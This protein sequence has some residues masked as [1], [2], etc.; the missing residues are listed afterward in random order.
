MGML[1][2]LLASAGQAADSSRN[3]FLPAGEHKVSI[4]TIGYK[5]GF[6]GLSFIVE[7]DVLEST[8]AAP[9]VYSVV[10]RKQSAADPGFD[11]DAKKW[12][13]AVATEIARNSGDP[14]FTPS[15][16]DLKPENFLK[17]CSEFKL[18]GYTNKE[19]KV[20][21]MSDV[22]GTVLLVSSVPGKSQKGVA[23]T[24]HNPRPS[25]GKAE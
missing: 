19:N 10:R 20:E 24:F 21:T 11:G 22:E 15:A 23:L 8:T 7:L 18:C 14:G 12:L 3:P 6:K 4:R 9:G 25:T 13:V 2:Q 16:D 1:E 5:D 17:L